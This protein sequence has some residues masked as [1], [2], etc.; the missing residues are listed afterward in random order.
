MPSLMFLGELAV[1]GALLGIIGIL[2]AWGLRK[3]GAAVQH[4][5]WRTLLA[6]MLLLPV[7]I[8]VLPPRTLM[9]SQSLTIQELEQS[10]GAVFSPRGTVALPLPSKTNAPVRPLMWSVG[11]PTFLLL[12]YVTIAVLL[13]VRTA[14]KVHRAKKLA[15]TARR[16]PRQA[17]DIGFVPFEV[18]ESADVDV[19]FTIGRRNPVIVLPGGWGQWDVF[20]LRSVL[21]HEMAHI[22]RADWTT[23]LVAMIHRALFWYHPIA[24]WLERRLSALA[25]EA[26]DAAAIRST[27]DGIRYA[28]V[29]LEF[30]RMA[31]GPR[32]VVG[33]SMART[34]KVGT[35]IHRILEG[36]VSSDRQIGRWA[37]AVIFALT[38]PSMYVAATVQ[39]TERSSTVS[40]TSEWAYQTQQALLSE[41]WH[42][43]P[44]EAVKLEAQ[45][46]TDPENI[47]IRSRLLSYY[48]QQVIVEPRA[49]HLMWMI[50]HHPDADIFRLGS[51]VTSL[52][53]PY[54]PAPTTL[55]DAE[56]G[57]ALWLRQVDRFPSNTKVL[58]NAV[59]ALLGHDGPIA[60]ELIRRARSLQP[61]DPQF[62][63]WL[64]SVYER[65]VRTTIAAPERVRALTSTGASTLLLGFPLPLEQSEAM[66]RELETSKDVSL[67]GETGELLLHETTALNRFGSTDS[68]VAESAAFAKQLLARAHELDPQNPRW[69]P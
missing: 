28:K 7:L 57:K 14:A 24:W 5:I 4:A 59:V 9:P 6:G 34:S 37:T 21:A 44:E 13:L 23:S 69:K 50:E 41:G 56:K 15:R 19:P 11:W 43:T 48:S 61:N 51:V 64:A 27:G 39:L 25:E 45:L 1:R 46:A 40:Y 17:I 60:L 67:V 22:Q 54:S 53:F 10:V 42:T 63:T 65:A 62:T 47:G 31:S 30:A 18:R 33:T 68:E 3:R 55:A 38:L 66:K 36:R 26:C 35:R 58:A 12:M 32:V 16:V 2:A 29:V 20:T 52:S 8:T 49:A